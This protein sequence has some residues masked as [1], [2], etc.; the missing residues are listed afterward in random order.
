MVSFAIVL[1]LSNVVLT[2]CKRLHLEHGAG[3]S[4]A[5]GFGL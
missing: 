3:F 5:A 4:T 2:L 1:M